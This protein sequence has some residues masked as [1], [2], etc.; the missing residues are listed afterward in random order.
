[1]TS[2]S[3]SVNHLASLKNRNSHG[4]VHL[5]AFTVNAWSPSPSCCQVWSGHA[6][7]K[8]QA[9]FLS[10]GSLPF[11]LKVIIPAQ[12]PLSAASS[13]SPPSWLILISIQTCWNI[14]HLKN[15]GIPWYHDLL[16]QLP[17]FSVPLYSKNSVK[18]L[19]IL[20]ISTTPQLLTLIC[21]QSCF[22]PTIPPMESCSPLVSAQDATWKMPE[23][24]WL[25]RK[26]SFLKGLEAIMSKAE[27]LGD[28]VP[29][30][31]FTPGL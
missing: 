11:L 26:C 4:Y 24:G 27:V 9:L 19:T 17:P 20:I 18:N 28:S 10:N 30:K 8:C 22:L 21:P 29:G 6:A 14:S 15:K 2:S 16:Q 25:K 1:M 5:A 13:L 7:I 31:G 12:T 3:L 23:T